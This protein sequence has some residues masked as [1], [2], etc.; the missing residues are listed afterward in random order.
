MDIIRIFTDN[1]FR[2][3]NG[4]GNLRKDLY[5]I[6]R[7]EK[8][9]LI[10]IFVDVVP[11]NRETIDI[12]NMLLVDAITKFPRKLLLV[13]IL[14][15]EYFYIKTLNNFRVD[16]DEELTK[17]Y[18]TV[19]PYDTEKIL[20]GHKKDSYSTYE[21]YGKFLIK[22]NAINCAKDIKQDNHFTKVG[23]TCQNSTDNCTE[24]KLQD[25]V[26]YLLSTYDIIPANNII[27]HVTPV[28]ID[29]ALGYMLDY[30]LRI[31]DL[32]SIYGETDYIIDIELVKNLVEVW[33][34]A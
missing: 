7:V 34:N 24:V 32:I 20:I 2:Y 33:N 16:I 22:Y 17:R 10:C 9:D 8:P 29:K 30:S 31:N 5:K 12:F 23:C 27:E 6:F 1:H 26:L 21:Q 15:S 3:S 18:L 11:N 19:L 14:G 25:K 4:N 28:S 13:P